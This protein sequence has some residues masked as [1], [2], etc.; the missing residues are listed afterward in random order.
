MFPS[1]PLAAAPTRKPEMQGLDRSR[2][3]STSKWSA[4]S[5]LHSYCPAMVASTP[6][7]R[8]YPEGSSYEA[9][10]DVDTALSRVLADFRYF[11]SSMTPPLSTPS[12]GRFGAMRS[13]YKPD[14]TWYRRGS[15]NTLPTYTRTNRQAQLC[16][17]APAFE[18]NAVL[19]ATGR[20]N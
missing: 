13:E 10:I 14:Q 20:N 6:S 4:S 16:R 15:L 17:P 7:S 3:F 8:T 5:S 9:P 18:G 11:T 1:A 19:V 12:C 2:T